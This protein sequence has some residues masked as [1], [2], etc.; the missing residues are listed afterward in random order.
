MYF[1][2][3][4]ANEELDIEEGQ[5]EEIEKP[6]CVDVET[7]IVPLASE[8][9]TNIQNTDKKVERKCPFGF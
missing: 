3:M 4:G 8:S 9:S 1:L 7:G 2:G 6:G 5:R